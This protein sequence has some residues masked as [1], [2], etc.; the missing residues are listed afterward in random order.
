ME[1]KDYPYGL[2]PFFSL[3]FGIHSME[4]KVAPARPSRSP[5]SVP[6]NPFNGIESLF[7]LTFTLLGLENPFN[8]I[9]SK[10]EPKGGG[11]WQTPC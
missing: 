8:G 9:E 2:P 3:S 11:L 1:L 4:L 5:L 7:L 6:W 10:V